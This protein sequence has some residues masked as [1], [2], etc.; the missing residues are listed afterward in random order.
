MQPAAAFTDVLDSLTGGFP[1]DDP[2]RSGKPGIA[3]RP[4]FSF[5]RPARTLSAPERAALGLF[6]SLGAEL[7][8]DFTRQDLRSGFRALARRFHPDVNP[9]ASGREFAAMRDAYEILSRRV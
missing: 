8:A 7:T 2:T 4:L 1:A 9:F 3:T 5:R 6:N